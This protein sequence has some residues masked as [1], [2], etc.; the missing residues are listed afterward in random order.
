MLGDVHPLPLN[1]HH[2]GIARIALPIVE[3][4]SLRAAGEPH[5]AGTAQRFRGVRIPQGQIINNAFIQALLHEGEVNRIGIRVLALARAGLHLAMPH[6][7]ANRGLIGRLQRLQRA[8]NKVIMSPL[9]QVG[10]ADDFHAWS[11]LDG[12]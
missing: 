11:H 2:Q 4:R 8:A 1:G 5:L 3:G 9:G 6:R 12:L 7:D 10:S